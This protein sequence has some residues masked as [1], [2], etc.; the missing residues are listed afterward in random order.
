MMKELKRR[1]WTNEYGVKYVN[2]LVEEHQYN[3]I[4]FVWYQD[5]IQ[6]DGKKFTSQI[7]RFKQL[8]KMNAVMEKY[9]F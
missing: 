1:E 3:N 6:P 8:K 4:Y 5:T 9:N 7:E 2:R